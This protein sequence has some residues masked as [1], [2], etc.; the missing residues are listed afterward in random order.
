V[1]SRGVASLPRLRSDFIVR[2]IIAGFRSEHINMTSLISW[3]GV[4]SRGVA[5]LYL[6]S[7]SRISWAD[8]GTWDYG[9]KLFAS[10]RYPHIFGY[11]G[12][13]LFPTQTLSQITEMLDD[14]LIAAN[15]SDSIDRCTERV[16]AIVESAFKTYPAKA[17]RDFDILYSMREGEGMQSRFHLR[18]ITFRA[19]SSATVRPFKIPDQSGL[20]VVLGSGSDSVRARLDQWTTTEVGGTSRAVFG[21]FCDSLQSG[22]DSLSAGPPQLVGLRRKSTAKTFGIVWQKGLYYYGLQAAL[23][24]YQ[25]RICW[26]NELFEI[27][28]PNTLERRADAQ[29]HP[30]PRGT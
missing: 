8:S 16:L 29:R 12:D 2:T 9:R 25:N 22:H 17:K 30:R 20:I 15:P 23:P 14:D 26:F 5:S 1:E 19:T 24:T 4:D 13:V 11:C 18:Q 28:D 6:A 27:C 7:D 10:R 3:V 21:S